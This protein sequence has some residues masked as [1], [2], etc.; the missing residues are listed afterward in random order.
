MGKSKIVTTVV[1][2]FILIFNS[3]SL[4]VFAETNHDIS[5]VI[6][7]PQVK[8]MIKDAMEDENA[9]GVSIVITDGSDASYYNFGYADINDGKKATE[10]TLYE[11]GSTTKAFTALAVLIL[12]DDGVISID[13][14]VSK[15]V[16]WFHVRYQDQN[17][18]V[19]IKQL[20]QHTSGLRSSIMNHFPEGTSEDLLEETVRL[21]EGTEL[22]F[23][24]GTQY[25]YANIGYDLLAYIIEAVTG[26][27]YE[28]FVTD[29]I[30]FP[31]GMKNSTFDYPYAINTGKMAQGYSQFFMKAREYNAPR[32]Q[33]CLADG[34]LITC[35]SDMGLWLNAQMGGEDVPEQLSRLIKKSH[36][37]EEDN[38]IVI[39]QFRKKP[40]YYTYG[41]ETSADGK[42]ITHSGS[43]PSYSSNIIIMPET[44]RSVCVMS[45]IQGNH[46]VDISQNIMRAF[47]GE[48]SYRQNSIN[49]PLD[50]FLSIGIVI[51]AV[52]IILIII[53]QKTSKKDV[54]KK[55]KS[56]TKFKKSL[57]IMKG[58]LCLGMTLALGFW[59]YLAGYNYYMVW[60][61]MPRTLIICSFVFLLLFLLLLISAL[62]ELF[63]LHPRRSQV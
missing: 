31:L 54:S 48:S 22:D 50:K 53:R 44:G 18:K 39:S 24:P 57:L 28:D 10:N 40:V 7:N 63:N 59:P 49:G 37:I 51:G 29:R 46:T 4:Q 20:L 60:V 3:Y 2:L 52:L 5:D 14:N 27:K 33:G 32:Y 55:R 41:W 16:P 13:D 61:W 23:M 58:V 45:N 11:L 25:E 19:T 6:N 30:L 47:L 9:P 15:Y 42:M 26:E 34:Y 56:K 36:E 21:T 38:T 35:S 62:L 12:E 43:N 8:Q 1:L 17:V